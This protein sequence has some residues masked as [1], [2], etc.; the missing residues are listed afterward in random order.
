MRQMF[1]SFQAENPLFLLL[2]LCIL[3]I[4]RLIDRV[5]HAEIYIIYYLN[6]WLV[7]TNNGP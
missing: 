7:K 6:E 1:L 5:F 4:F 2:T 3:D